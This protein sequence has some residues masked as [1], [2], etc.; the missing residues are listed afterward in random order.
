MA[1][2]VTVTG[3]LVSYLVKE[4]AGK[5]LESYAQDFLKGAVKSGVQGVEGRLKGTAAKQA[6]REFA[7]AFGAEL[8]GAGLTESQAKQ[9]RK[10]LVAFVR[11][12]DVK[13]VLA[14]PFGQGC[15]RVDVKVL[16]DRWPLVRYKKGWRHR[17]RRF[18]SEKLRQQ[19]PDW[20]EGQPLPFL[21]QNFDWGR[22][23]ETYFAAVRRLVREDDEL[24]GALGFDALQGIAA[25]QSIQ[26]DFSVAKYA[27]GLLERYGNL[28]LEKVATSWNAQLKLWQ[29]FVP[30]N[31]REVRDYLPQLAE[32]P[33]AYLEELRA[34]GQL[35]EEFD[36]DGDRELQA[37]AFR[38]SRTDSILRFLESEQRLVVLGDPGSGKS[39]LIQKLALDWARLLES[40]PTELEMRPL[41]LVVELRRYIKEFEANRCKSFLDFFHEGSG[42]PCRLNRLALD[43]LLKRGQAIALFDGLDEIFDQGD[44]ERVM[45]DIHRFT[46]DYPQVKVIVTSRVIGYKAGPLKGAGFTQVL[47]EDLDGDQKSAF[48][49]QWYKLTYPNDLEKRREKQTE[50]TQALEHSPKIR[51]LAGNP[52]L[53]T[54]MA[55]LTRSRS[56]PRD[57]RTLYEKSAELLIEQWG[58]QDKNI[59][60]ELKS[61]D[62]KDKVDILRKV[63]F[64]VQVNAG[65][66]SGNAIGKDDLERIFIEEFQA[67]QRSGDLKELAA[68]LREQLR[69]RNFILCDLGG[70]YYGFVHRTFLEFFCADEIAVRFNRR[71]EPNVRDSLSP[72]KLVA[73]FLD[74]WRDQG[75][76]E[77]LRLLAGSI[78]AGFVGPAITKLLG[79]ED[80]SKKTA[81]L[82]AAECLLEVRDTPLLEELQSQ[83]QELLVKIVV[84]EDYY[85]VDYDDYFTFGSLNSIDNRLLKRVLGTIAGLGRG[86]QKTF[87]LF[88]D[89]IENDSHKDVRRAA[90]ESLVQ[91]YGDHSE[92][93]QF[94]IE[95]V[96][97]DA[98][99]DVRHAAVEVLVQHYGDHPETFDLA[100]EVGKTDNVFNMISTAVK[101]LMQHYGDHPETFDVTVEVGRTDSTFKMIS[102]VVDF[103]VQRYGD[104]PE[105]FE[106][107]VKRLKKH[108]NPDVRYA[109]VDFLAQ[110]Y[111]DRPETLNVLVEQ[112]KA[113]S[114][115]YVRRAAMKVL[116]QHYGDRPETFELVVERVKTDDNCYARR[117]AVEVLAQPHYRDNPETRSILEDRATSEPD[118][119]LRQWIQEQLK[120]FA[121]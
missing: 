23:G 106:L 27:E 74:H 13:R 18:S 3:L 78:P 26:V 104:R 92:T 105:T 14:E 4:I 44:R 35:P 64:F 113:D 87:E 88:V 37:R 120:N 31:A 9:F 69:G 109:A 33:K 46:N 112:A 89:W 66:K 2:P 95:R 110:R 47:L 117:T 48:A 24:R 60:S 114:S 19:Y 25:A 40:A 94:L 10:P 102:T 6:L 55:I 7:G 98:N 5:A 99:Q 17:G 79:E 49:D 96:K 16:G 67:Q 118:Q 63:A 57:R 121:D 43:E 70:S 68:S 111:G 21:P 28:Q 75:W 56:L 58:L 86:S 101:F 59:E 12:A 107:F 91:H 72:S 100:V 8:E 83:V 53:L 65:S 108:A 50:L 97:V 45:T 81:L 20:F 93:F 90:V 1:E 34:A 61:L 119:E 71:D 11:D 115:S 22:L 51:E 32:L 39:T 38:E 36:E 73:F 41:P 52:L 85:L 29:V 82:L 30:Q 15:R 77:V 84:D 103:L 54:L 80:N 62:Y 42:L 76:H 116:S